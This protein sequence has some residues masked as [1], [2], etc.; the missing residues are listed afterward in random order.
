MRQTLNEQENAFLQNGHP[1]Q[2]HFPYMEVHSISDG[3]EKPV[4]RLLRLSTGDRWQDQAGC[5]WEVD[6]TG[7]VY[8]KIR[9]TI[10]THHEQVTHSLEQH[11]TELAGQYR[12]TGYRVQYA[13]PC[14]ECHS[15]CS[16]VRHAALPMSGHSNTADTWS[17]LLKP[18]RTL[19][20]SRHWITSEVIMCVWTSDLNPWHQGRMDA[21]GHSFIMCRQHVGIKSAVH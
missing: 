11:I 8:L 18:N 2:R 6:Q 3:E 10:Q 12:T 1:S 16:R 20:I 9:N 7:N 19:R 4:H 14:R 15:W 5:L 13:R 17:P 21:P